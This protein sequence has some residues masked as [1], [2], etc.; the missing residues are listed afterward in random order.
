MRR[1]LISRE[2]TYPTWRKP[3][4]HPVKICQLVRDMLVPAKMQRVLIQEKR[5]MFNFKTHRNQ[6]YPTCHISTLVGN[7]QTNLVN[8][9]EL[10]PPQT[11]RISTS[12]RWYYLPIP[13]V[14]VSDRT[15][16]RTKNGEKCWTCAPVG[17]GRSLGMDT[18]DL[19]GHA[20]H[21]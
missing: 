15:N 19:G 16:R 12:T 7:P 3:E 17:E 21:P 9:R 20:K 2:L 18:G 10:Q 4:N 1:S 14:L 5:I 8:H 6:A 11:V 13:D